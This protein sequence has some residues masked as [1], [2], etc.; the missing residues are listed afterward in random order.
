MQKQFN[1]LPPLCFKVLYNF[2]VIQ[3]VS[4]AAAVHVYHFKASWCITMWMVDDNLQWLYITWI[5]TGWVHVVDQR[6]SVRCRCLC[7]GGGVCTCAWLS[8]LCMGE[9]VCAYVICTSRCLYTLRLS[10]VRF[11][12]LLCVCVCCAFRWSWHP[13]LSVNE[14]WRW[15]LLLSR[16]C[17]GKWR[18]SWSW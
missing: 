9:C 11:C 2:S 6:C 17:R 1:N 15:M 14:V 12:T 7:S 13:C 18:S 10:F 16:Y 3:C 4:G 8:C 5:M